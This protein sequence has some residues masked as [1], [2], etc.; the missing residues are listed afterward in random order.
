MMTSRERVLAAIEHREPDRVPIDVGGSSMTTIIGEGY[1]RLK[2]HLGVTAET[3]YIKQRSRTVLLAEPVA[4]RLGTD[5]RPLS[6]GAPDGW[7]D[8]YFADGS[9]Q[10]EWKVI[11]TKAEGG[12]YNPTGNPL[13]DAIS[14]DLDHFPWPDPLNPGRIRG[15]RER[16]RRLHEE[17]DYA[18]ILDL[19]V[20][21]I[22]QSQY[23]RGYENFLVDLIINPGCYGLN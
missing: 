21:F 12:H 15:L 17:T 6:L 5:T 13:R 8:V 11:W 4:H 18:I 2:L 23:L 22:H 19:P 20:G 7:Q 9:T 10:D 14:A 1:Q 3:H 16:A